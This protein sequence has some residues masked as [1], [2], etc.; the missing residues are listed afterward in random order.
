[1][2]QSGSFRPG[3]IVMLLGSLAGLAVAL[4]AYFTP[5][6]GVNGSLGALVVILSTIAL[7]ILTL[8]LAPLSHRSGRVALRVLIL[9]DLVGTGFAGLLLHQWWLTAAMVVGLIGLLLE[10]AS[11]AS[12]TTPAHS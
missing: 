5:L 4:Y 6:T 3:I 2:S 12:S 8:V 11:S 1:M 7:A 10:M 9:L